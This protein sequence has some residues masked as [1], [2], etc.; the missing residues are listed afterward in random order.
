[1]LPHPGQG[2]ARE[3]LAMDSLATFIPKAPRSPSAGTLRLLAVAVALCMPTTPQGA[4]G[5]PL[6]EFDDLEAAFLLFLAGFGGL[7]RLVVARF[8]GNL[9]LSG[10]R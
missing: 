7:P 8:H 3:G 10:L 4:G 2:R 9:L 1:M 5:D 6:F